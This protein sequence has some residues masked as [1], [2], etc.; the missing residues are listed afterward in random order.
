LRDLEIARFGDCF[1]GVFM[2]NLK[3]TKSHN[4]QFLRTAGLST[5][6]NQGY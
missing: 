4:Q 3:I 1:C 6:K 2:E 5:L